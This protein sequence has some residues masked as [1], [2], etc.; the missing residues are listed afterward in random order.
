MTPLT[1][2]ARAELVAIDMHVHLGD[3]RARSFNVARK[4]AMSKYL[5]T[6][7]PEVPVDDM[8]DAYRERRMM[9]VIMNT[10]DT[11]RTGEPSLPNDYVAEVVA[12]HPDVFLGFG[13][14]DPALGEAAV[15]EAV[16]CHEELGLIG[17]G[18]L[19][20]ARQHFLPHDPALT[21]MWSTL[22]DLGMAA[23]FHGGYAASGSGT[24]GG[25]GV[26]LRYG[27]P[28]Y[29]DDVAADHPRLRIICAHPSWPWESEALAVAQ[30]KA[31]VYLDLSGWAPKYFS[32]QLVRYV[33]SRIP[34]KV[35]FGSDWP[36]L[37]VERWIEE[38]TALELPEEVVRK[39]LLDNARTFLGVE[40]P[41]EVVTPQADGGAR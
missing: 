24:P 36:V 9:A 6:S 2:A 37:E 34:G 1:Y 11:A 18:E 35:L 19:N 32:T 29:L 17:I 39:V 31:N 7:R 14:V 21:A 40:Q 23:L 22:E 5:G 16:R 10:T 8:A 12:R 3:A 28:I 25:S 15:L 26:K 4:K 30:H 41:D 33:R 13:V 20:A 27:R 38:F